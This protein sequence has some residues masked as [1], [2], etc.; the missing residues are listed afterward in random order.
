MKILPIKAN[1][2]AE[3]NCNTKIQ[4]ELNA[5]KHVFQYKK[6]KNPRIRNVKTKNK[7]EQKKTGRNARE[8]TELRKE[9]ESK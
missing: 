4:T 7:N 8:L 5:F 1:H 3:E 6:K 2:E 9:I